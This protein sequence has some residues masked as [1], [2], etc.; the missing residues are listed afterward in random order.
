MDVEDAFK[1]PKHP[2]RIAI[3]CAMWLTGFDVECL[4]REMKKKGRRVLSSVHPRGQDFRII[5]EC[6]GFYGTRCN[7]DI[8]FPEQSHG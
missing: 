7:Q 1:D 8:Q 6:E 4:A 2:F 5:E 3:V